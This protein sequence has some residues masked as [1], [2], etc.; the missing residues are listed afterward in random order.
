MSSGFGDF[1]MT[2][3]EKV[4][5]NLATILSFIAGIITITDHLFG[6]GEEGVKG[7]IKMIFDLFPEKIDTFWLIITILAMVILLAN[8]NKIPLLGRKYKKYG[9]EA[10]QLK[11]ELEEK[12]KQYDEIAERIKLPFGTI[13]TAEKSPTWGVSFPHTDIIMNNPDDR[14]GKFPYLYFYIRVIN[15]T[16]YSFEPEEVTIR[17]SYNGQDV[18]RDE[19]DR[20]IGESQTIK[21]V[22]ELPK[23]GDGTILFHV[24]IKKLYGNLEKWKLKGTIKYKSKEPL[25][26]DNS[27]YA[28]P[29]ISINL[30]F[31]LPEKQISK[32]KEQ[33]ERRNQ[34]DKTDAPQFIAGWRAS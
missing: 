23:F 27:Q 21:D 15:R 33:V 31:V 13:I 22:M 10:K 3:L 16:Y 12:T 20:R 9:E 18:F 30:E 8:F 17:C 26:Y 7:M 24:P 2:M 19:W 25:I 32:L 34:M 1:V 6:D 4:K 5:E 14:E 28:N 11:I 29:E